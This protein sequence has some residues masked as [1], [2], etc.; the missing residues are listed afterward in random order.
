MI[1]SR[2]IQESQMRGTESL[3]SLEL[4]ARVRGDH[5]LQTIRE[6]VSAWL[7][8]L[9][10]DYGALHGRRAALDRAGEVASG[11]AGASVSGIRSERQVIRSLAM[12][13]L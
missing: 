2:L 1:L 7:S 12:E 13:Y 8:D 3:F 5:S 6:I 10:G 9:S 4:E 11:E